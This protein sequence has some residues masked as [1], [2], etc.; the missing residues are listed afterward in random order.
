MWP[1]DHYRAIVFQDELDA[2][3]AEVTARFK[4]DMSDFVQVDRPAV[5]VKVQRKARIVGRDCSG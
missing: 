5:A 1:E 3:V 2:T 4:V